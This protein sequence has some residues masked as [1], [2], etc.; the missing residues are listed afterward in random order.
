MNTQLQPGDDDEEAANKLQMMQLK[1]MA[2]RC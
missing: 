1:K 2:L